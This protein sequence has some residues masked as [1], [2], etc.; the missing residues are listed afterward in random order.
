[1]QSNAKAKQSKGAGLLV[2]MHTALSRQIMRQDV[3]MLL[4]TCLLQQV[5]SVAIVSVQGFA[6]CH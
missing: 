3:N 2:A 4:H 1:V 5:A 6:G